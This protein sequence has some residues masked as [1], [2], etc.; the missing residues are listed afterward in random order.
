MSK[1]KEIE[2]RAKTD[3]DLKDIVN[4]M[5]AF[6]GLNIKKTARSLGA[7]REYEEAVKDALAA[8]A[9]YLPERVPLKGG[10]GRVLVVFGSDLGLCGPFNERIAE[11]V[12][13]VR[14]QHDLVFVVGRRLKDKL[15]ILGAEYAGFLDSVATIEGVRS[16]M[17]ESFSRI[18]GLYSRKEASGLVFIFSCLSEKMEEAEVVLE[19]VLP[20]EQASGAKPP[21]ERP[22]LY[23]APETVFDEII[24]EFMYISLYRCYIESLRTENWYRFKS[25]EGSLESIEAKIKELDALYRYSRQE[26]ITQ[27][28]IEIIQSHSM[29]SARE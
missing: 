9:S 23:L 11:F 18:A 27:E 25:M 20:P 16:A 24:G 1:S 7:I 6:A 22:L 3:G 13:K 12:V 15:D 4:A 8:T 28:I 19:K 10:P 5:K 26:E 17:L 2:D 29:S 14:E 21:G